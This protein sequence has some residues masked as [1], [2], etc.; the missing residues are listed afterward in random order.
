MLELSTELEGE[1]LTSTG[2]VIKRKPRWAG[3]GAKGGNATGTFSRGIT[4]GL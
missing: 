1:G 4:M 2:G 3:E